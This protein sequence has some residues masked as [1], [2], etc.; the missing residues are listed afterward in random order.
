MVETSTGKN[1]TERRKPLRED[2]R[3]QQHREQQTQHRLQ[4][5]GEDGEDQGVDQAAH[6]ERLGEELDVV[7]EAREPRLERVQSVRLK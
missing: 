5:R 6:E 7:V 1:T 2:A 4:P 3:G